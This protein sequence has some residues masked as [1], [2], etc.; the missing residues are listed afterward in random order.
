MFTIV[1]MITWCRRLKSSTRSVSRQSRPLR[2]LYHILNHCSLRGTFLLPPNPEDPV[3]FNRADV[4]AA[5]HAPEN[6]DWV[7]CTDVN[8]FPNGDTSLP[9]TF[10]VLPNVIEKSERAVIANGRADFIIMAEGS[11]IA[12]Q[13]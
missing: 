9:P 12:L 10:T 7:L 1:W 8:V 2:C 3:Y 11:R 13:K 4:K 6:V 5:I